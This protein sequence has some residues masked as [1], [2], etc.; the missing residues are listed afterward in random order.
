MKKLEKKLKK[1]AKSSVKI[2]SNY[3]CFPTWLPAKNEEGVYL[4]K[5]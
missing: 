3:F 2:I 4:Y 5:K 1:E